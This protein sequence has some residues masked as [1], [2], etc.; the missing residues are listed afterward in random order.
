[1]NRVCTCEEARWKTAKDGKLFC[2]ACQGVMY[3]FHAKA[4]GEPASTTAKGLDTQ[5]VLVSGRN[6]MHT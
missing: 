6:L 4:L 5:T 1:M 3:Y 2:L